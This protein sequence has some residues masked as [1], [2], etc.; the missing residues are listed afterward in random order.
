MCWRDRLRAD[1]GSWYLGVGKFQGGEL[2]LYRSFSIFPVPNRRL[3]R[4]TLSLGTRREAVGAEEELLPV[5]VVITRCQVG[6]RLLELAMSP[7]AATGL[8]AWLEAVPPSDH[9]TGR[10]RRTG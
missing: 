5:G 4:Q 9:S 8:M 7:D 6:E 1:G 3:D 2:Q 10:L